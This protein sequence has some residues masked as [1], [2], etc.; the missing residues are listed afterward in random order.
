MRQVTKPAH[1]GLVVP[2]FGQ[3]GDNHGIPILA[4][5]VRLLAEQHKVTVYALRYPSSPSMFRSSGADVISFGGAGKRGIARLRFLL[6]SLNFITRHANHAGISL[7]HG[8]WADEPGFLAAVAAWR[9]RI[10]SVVTLMGGELVGLSDIKYGGRLSHVN[11]LL[12]RIGTRLADRVTAGSL[13]MVDRFARVVRRKHPIHLPLGVDADLFASGNT[14]PAKPK[15]GSEFRLLAVGSLVPVKDHQ[16]LLHAFAQLHPGDP[17]MTLHII[18]DGELRSHLEEVGEALGIM[19]HVVFHGF[20]PRKNL[21]AHYREADVFVHTSRFESQGLVLLEAACFG[22]PV[23]GTGVG[24]IPELKP[25]VLE[26]PVGDPAALAAAILK[27]KV[28][29]TYRLELG[30]QLASRVKAR[31]TLAR[32]LADLADLYRELLTV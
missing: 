28:D 24:L 7:I 27:L 21:P 23:I 8:F 11:P 14:S 31:Y 13:S 4:D 22:L 20:I 10:P 2:G 29:N 32:T 30:S 17:G 5:I 6:E 9:L 26:V 12:T 25:A 16:T 19:R 15:T 18:G 3:D 1:L